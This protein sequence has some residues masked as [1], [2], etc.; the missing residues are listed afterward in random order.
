[1]TTGTI[2]Q[3]RTGGYGMRGDAESLAAAYEAGAPV[4][5]T[6][7]PY[8]GDRL[9]LGRTGETMGDMG[10]RLQTE[11]LAY[12]KDDGEAVYY[13]DTARLS[14]APAFRA[15]LARVADEVAAA[16]AAMYARDEEYLNPRY[17]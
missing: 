14:E 12:M 13:V 8:S 16:D 1:M 17:M 15:E 2:V 10:R 3:L 7:G 9:Y 11:G 5:P 4:T 6:N